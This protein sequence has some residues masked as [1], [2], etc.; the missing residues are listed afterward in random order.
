MNHLVKLIQLLADGQY[1]SGEDLG[2]ALGISR[3]AV[4]KSLKQLSEYN[5]PLMST[6]GRGYCI[7][8]GLELLDRDHICS[9][10]SADNQ[11][12]LTECVLVDSV[13][14]TNQFLLDKAKNKML[15]GVAC[16]AEHQSA[17]RGRQNREWISPFGQ[18]I[19]LSL[20][21]QFPGGAASLAGLSLAVGVAAVRAL[22]QYGICDVT[23]KW[24]NDIQI[25]KKKL[26]GV[27]VELFGDSAG[28]CQVVIGVGLNLFLEK[29]IA[30]EIDQPW[31]D[32]QTA[33]GMRPERNKIAGLLL[34][35][36]LEITQDFAE[37]GLANTL[38][39][40]QRVDALC[41]QSIKVYSQE[42]VYDGICKGVSGLGEL[43]VDVNGK[44]LTFHSGDVTV[45]GEGGFIKKETTNW[46]VAT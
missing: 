5:V 33:T 40:W 15:T 20:A 13:N 24:P 28:P 3:S 16:F 7:P 14:S 38:K 32:L 44:V 42:K 37:N 10:L 9:L 41:G 12:L 29:N 23:L 4:W 31:I 1:H 43:L 6:H 39:D 34:N 35:N 8:D 36:L 21:W 25:N 22:A 45:R 17:G 11:A 19:Y 27:L 2:A 46:S 26:G 18:N 30:S